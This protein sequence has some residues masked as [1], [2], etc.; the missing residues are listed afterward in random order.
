MS[1]ITK[2]YSDAIG[3]IY[4]SG[5]STKEKYLL[6]DITKIAFSSAF[7]DGLLDNIGYLTLCN[8]QRLCKDVISLDEYKYEQALANGEMEELEF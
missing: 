2:E 3:A 6:L 1:E 8:S 7:Q 5:V 4:R